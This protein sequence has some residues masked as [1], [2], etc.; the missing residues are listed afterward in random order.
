MSQNEFDLDRIREL[1]QRRND[2]LAL[3]LEYPYTEMPDLD[4]KISNIYDELIE[5]Q[6]EGKAP[7]PGDAWKTL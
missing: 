2:I 6:R 7:P 5:M 4:R 1:R 3:Q